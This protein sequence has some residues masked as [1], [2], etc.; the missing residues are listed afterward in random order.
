[1][2]SLDGAAATRQVLATRPGSAVVALAPLWN[3]AQ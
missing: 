3:L 1:M 2:S